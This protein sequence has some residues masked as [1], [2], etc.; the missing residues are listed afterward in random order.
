M[1][2]FTADICDEQQTKVKVLDPIFKSYGGKS[3]FKGEIVTIRLEG[4]NSD[5]I[6]LLK[7]EGCQRVCVVD[8]SGRYVAVVGEN[9][10]KLAQMNNWSG[11]VINGYVRDIVFTKK[12]DIGLLALGTCPA[13][14]A[15]GAKGE[16]DVTVSIG[17]IE[18]DSGQMLYADED[19]VI[20]VD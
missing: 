18:I 15:K 5:L 10:M 13:K 9:L 4:D 16:R 12:I 1:S 3:K 14:S 19:G 8:V 6:T 20:I 17:G 7:Q 2:F 11:I